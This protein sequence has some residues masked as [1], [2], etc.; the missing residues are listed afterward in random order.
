MQDKHFLS[1]RAVSKQA[2]EMKKRLASLA[3]NSQPQRE[4]V[5]V[6]GRIKRPS[7]QSKKTSMLKMPKRSA[8]S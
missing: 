1:M 6:Y 2:D 8:T 7:K 3:Q 5:V 4:I